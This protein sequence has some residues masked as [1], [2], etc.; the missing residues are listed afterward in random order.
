MSEPTTDR[1]FDAASLYGST[2]WCGR[3]FGR[4]RDWFLRNKGRLYA[5]GFPQPDPVVGLYLKAAVY[6]WVDQRTNCPNR[7]TVTPA[8]DEGVNA[9]AF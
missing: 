9:D 7:D 6:A 8:R 1:T 2:L 5:A 3:M 4:S